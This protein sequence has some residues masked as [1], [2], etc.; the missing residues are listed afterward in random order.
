MYYDGKVSDGKM[1][2]F[3][4]VL[5]PDF[6]LIFQILNF[7]LLKSN[8]L[9]PKWSVSTNFFLE[10]TVKYREHLLTYSIVYNFITYLLQI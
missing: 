1:V 6:V 3:K 10:K 7:F 4:K 2:S 5:P 8:T 9:L